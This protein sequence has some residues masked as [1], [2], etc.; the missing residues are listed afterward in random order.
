M[1]VHLERRHQYFKHPKLQ[2][3][4]T[5]EHPDF[6]ELEYNQKDIE[7][8][9]FPWNSPIGK[10][11]VFFPSPY[12]NFYPH[13]FFSDT[14]LEQEENKKRNS[15]REFNKT[16]FEFLKKFV[17][18]SLQQ[19]N[20][21]FIN[22]NRISHLPLFSEPIDK[23]NF[24]KIYKC[25]K[26][27]VQTLK[28]FLKLNEIH[29]ANKFI[30]Y[31]YSNRQQQQKQHRDNDPLIDT[32]RLQEFLLS[33]IDFIVQSE[34]KIL[35][36]MVFPE[37][38]IKN[39][40]Y[41]KIMIH[42]MDLLGIGTHPIRWLLELVEN[43]GFKD[44]GDI[45]SE[46]WIKRGYDCHSTEEK[47]TILKKEELMQFIS[48]TEGTIGLIKFRLDKKVIYTFSYLRL[49]NEKTKQDVDQ[50][51]I[52]YLFSQFIEQGTEENQTEQLPQIIKQIDVQ[53]VDG[54]RED[55]DQAFEH[56][57]EELA[58]ERCTKGISIT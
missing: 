28:P 19:R 13:P 36:V 44:L 9:Q 16:L 57:I 30:H 34:N 54:I 53:Q 27:F 49:H 48:I 50:E 42:L 31:C 41:I 24:Y 17:M 52:S 38:L 56:Y 47:I 51:A 14:Q 43:E 2:F 58:R 4:N 5:K 55:N 37:I 29:P 8:Y 11:S 39:G 22:T 7:N 10:S 26:C 18:P 1:Q 46:H 40:F 3:D 23:H 6:N 45:H 25:Y 15:E 20:T 33:N 12:F 35:K 32:S 21:Q